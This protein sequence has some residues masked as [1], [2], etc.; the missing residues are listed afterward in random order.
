MSNL[1]KAWEALNLQQGEINAGLRIKTNGDPDYILV[2][3]SARHNQGVAAFAAEGWAKAV[4]GELPS[5]E[6][7][8]LIRANSSLLDDL[9][10]AV[11]SSDFYKT[12]HRALRHT[13]EVG[14]TPQT[15]LTAFAVRKVFIN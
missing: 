5:M 1:R 9:E 14:V 2:V 11:V 3:L 10:T 8:Y 4:G 6:D 15:K 7:L 13:A 12:D